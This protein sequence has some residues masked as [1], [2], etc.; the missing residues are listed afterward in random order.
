MGDL[1]IIS[2]GRVDAHDGVGQ[3]A[4]GNTVLTYGFSSNLPLTSISQAFIKGTLSQPTAAA[5]LTTRP[6]E[7]FLFS[8]IASS[9]GPA[10]R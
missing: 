7:M 3:D 1:H 6:K 5:P 8:I 9:P 2:P 10:A 4:C